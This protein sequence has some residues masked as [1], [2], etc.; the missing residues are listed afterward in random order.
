MSGRIDVCPAPLP[1][2]VVSLRPARASYVIG[3]DISGEKAAR[4][5]TDLQ[6]KVQDAG[7]ELLVTVPGHRVDVNLEAD[8]IEEV[9]RMYGYDRIP[10]TLPY[11]QSTQGIR[12]G[13]QLFLKRIRDYLAGAGLYEVVTYSFIHPRV[14]DRMNLPQ[15][16]LLRNAV[17]IQNPLSEEHSVMRTMMLPGLL[18]IL[19]RNYSRRVQDGAVFEIG[20]V[21]YPRGA[22]SLPEERAVL[23]AAA[24]GSTPG[25]WN[26][27][28]LEMDFYFLK[29]VLERLF[30]RIAA[31]PVQFRPE[32]ANPSFH[33]GR[34]ASLETGG[35]SLG[36]L[37][38]LHP[39]VLEH[40]ELPD[41]VVALEIDLAKLFEVRKSLSIPPPAE[42]PRHREGHCHRG[43]AGYAGRRDYGGNPKEGGNILRSVALF[44]LYRGEQVPEGHQ[45]MAYTLEFQAADRTL[46][47]EEADAGVQRIAS[48]LARNFGAVLRG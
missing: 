31:R 17:K 30:C 22:E 40:Y 3:V 47:D 16:S 27:A 28:P 21:F 38:E 34:C 24:M 9:A 13:E 7:E 35:V 43:Q 42:I 4:I 1:E 18:E 25:S 48:A 36:I 32:T 46:T 23:S 8:L 44:D 14:F 45:S 10:A 11:G 39:D 15:E 20:R 29:G 37:G 41:R 2:R 26:I 19:A 33:P 5:L 12:T 6:F